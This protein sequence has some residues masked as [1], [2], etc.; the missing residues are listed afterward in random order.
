MQLLQCR[1]ETQ[2]HR[3]FLLNALYMS[4]NV[5]LPARESCRRMARHTN[6]IILV[7]LTGAAPAL[8]PACF[9]F[10]WFSPAAVAAPVNHL[11]F[12]MHIQ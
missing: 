11:N 6:L 1:G 12:A 10:F 2:S 5:V 7:Q 3:L 9:A 4:G 8:P